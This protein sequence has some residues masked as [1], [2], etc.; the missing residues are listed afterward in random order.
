MYSLIVLNQ[1]SE[2]SLTGLKIEM[3]AGPVGSFDGESILR[4]FQLSEAAGV[5]RFVTYM[6]DLFCHAITFSV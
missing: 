6:T 5:S 3:P 4:F 1:K 2:V